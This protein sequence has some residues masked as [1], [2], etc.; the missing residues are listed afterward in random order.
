M[1][2]TL[3]NGDTATYTLK[4]D[5][6]YEVEFVRLNGDDITPDNNTVTLTYDKLLSSNTLEVGFVATSVKDAEE[7]AGIDNVTPI[8]VYTVTFDSNGGSDVAD[9][10]VQS[11]GTVTKPTNPTKKGY[12]F[13]G[14][15]TDHALTD[16]YDFSTPVTADITLYAKWKKTSV[17]STTSSHSKI[18]ATSTPPTTSTPSEVKNDQS[19]WENPFTDVEENDWYY[20]AVQFAVDNGLFI[21]STETEFTPNDDMT[22]GM[23]ATVL[24]RLA[25]TPEITVSQSFNDIADGQYYTDAVNWAAEKGIVYGY[26][27]GSFGHE[28]SIT[29][30]QLAV[31]LWRYAGSPVGNGNTDSF[32]DGDKVSTWAADALKWAVE[33]KIVNGKGNGILDPGGN[34]TRAEVAMMLMTYCNTM[35]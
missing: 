7:D 13:D 16:A 4:P 21:G 30:E 32:T 6:G 3:N 25:K 12:R 24:Y 26:G 2:R 34:A 14:W 18:P 27:D 17:G 1:V 23:L 11:K 15:Y 19:A 28:D 5:E 8:T 9:A 20:D 29:R 22:R 31:I 10:Q 33:Q 35:Q